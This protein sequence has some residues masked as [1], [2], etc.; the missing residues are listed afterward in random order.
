MLEFDFQN[1]K[2]KD[3]KDHKNEKEEFYPSCA[4]SLL[5][6]QLLLLG[7]FEA[8]RSCDFCSVEAIY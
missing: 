6:L 3:H 4:G 5:H 1:S 8:G 7:L 2:L